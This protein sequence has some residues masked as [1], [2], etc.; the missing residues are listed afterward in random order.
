[1]PLRIEIPDA[2]QLDPGLQQ[3]LLR[4]QERRQLDIARVQLDFDDR[5]PD[6]LKLDE[7]EVFDGE[8]YSV[9]ISGAA[10]PSRA[11]NSS[12]FGNTH[13]P[14]GVTSMVSRSTQASSQRGA[15]LRLSNRKG[16]RVNI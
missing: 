9:I 8:G 1:V 16:K 13:S 14:S 10:S 6:N 3:L 15:P 2:E 12:L 11:R 4:R 5:L 7:T